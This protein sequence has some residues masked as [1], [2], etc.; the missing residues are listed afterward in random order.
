MNVANV[1]WGI[2][3]CYTTYILVRRT[4]FSTF[5]ISDVVVRDRDS[6]T[7]KSYRSSTSPV[8]PLAL[9][10]SLVLLPTFSAWD[11]AQNQGDDM[12]SGW[13][14]SDDVVI[15]PSSSKKKRKRGDGG[16]DGVGGSNEEGHADGSNEQDHAGDGVDTG[17][18]HVDA[19]ELESEWAQASTDSSVD[20][21]EIKTPLDAVFP[22][23]SQSHSIQCSDSTSDSNV[24]S[25][26]LTLTDPMDLHRGF[27]MAVPSG[28]RT[29]SGLVLVLPSV[30]PSPSHHP[31]NSS[32]SLES[33]I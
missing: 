25:S 1:G 14:Q 7:I 5:T 3:T 8:S 32:Q 13:F 2:W 31:R 27:K 6:D 30:I 18:D 24:R 20:S 12:L 9:L 16:G 11:R 17:V 4:G 15:G 10:L 29:R 26:S 19:D 23:V 28:K 22:K 21:I 33:Q